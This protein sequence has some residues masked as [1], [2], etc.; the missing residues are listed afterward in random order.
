MKKIILF[1]IG[2]VAILA[3]CAV[4]P[5]VT[6]ADMAN[7]ASQYCVQQGGKVVMNKE[8]S[9]VVGYCHLPDGNVVEEWSLYKAAN[10]SE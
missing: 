10:P 9:G 1:S 7:P 3:G 6:K 8:P 5:K 2:C 4:E